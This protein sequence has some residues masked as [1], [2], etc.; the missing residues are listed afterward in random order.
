MLTKLIV[1]N[2]RCFAKR[3]EVP[4]ER[5][6]FLFGPNAAGKSALL[7]A[8]NQIATLIS[9]ASRPF[10]AIFSPIGPYSLRNQACDAERPIRLGVVYEEPALQGVDTLAYELELK[11]GQNAVIGDEQVLLN[12]QEIHHVSATSTTLV[13]RDFPDPD[14]QA[15]VNGFLAWLLHLRR[16]RLSPPR[17]RD[18]V[19]LEEQLWIEATGYRLPAAIDYM[20]QN[21]K[22]A[23]ER[24]KRMY[25]DLFPAVMGLD[26]EVF[27]SECGL[28][29]ANAAG[30]GLVGAHLSDGQAVSL[31]IAF[32]LSSPN[33]PNFLCI[34]E[35]ENGL[36]PE[37]IRKL[38]G[39]VLE[40]TESKAAVSQVITTTHSPYAIS[41]ADEFGEALQISSDG[42]VRTISD[43]LNQFGATL[44]GPVNS[45]QACALLEGY[46]YS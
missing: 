2:Y 42:R 7:D 18:K 20:M 26:V 10:G 23:W 27:G 24:L 22:D 31:A 38:L 46:W 45:R 34:E 37:L 28:K 32:M 41:W 19:P 9:G 17:I 29:Y 40:C 1:E 6:T 43:V 25:A 12:G 4:L 11:Q 13:R 16:Y 36:S 39:H 30:K 44:D 33:A 3:T 8:M 14:T 15:V 5:L 21:D 35:L